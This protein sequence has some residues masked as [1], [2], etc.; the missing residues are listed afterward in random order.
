MPLWC[1]G[2]GEGLGAQISARGLETPGVGWEGERAAGS[3]FPRSPRAPHS[4]SLQVSTQLSLPETLVAPERGAAPGECGE[5]GMAR[6][7]GEG[8]ALPAHRALYQGGGGGTTAGQNLASSPW[9]A[10]RLPEHAE[11][12]HYPARPPPPQ[13]RGVQWAPRA[14]GRGPRSLEGGRKCPVGIRGGG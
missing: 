1:G 14:A 11:R 7:R 2:G 3:W 9:G 4:V 6:E 10:L 5:A 12:G 8:P 13:A